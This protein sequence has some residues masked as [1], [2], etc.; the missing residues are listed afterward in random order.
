MSAKKIDALEKSAIENKKK[1]EQLKAEVEQMKAVAA[2]YAA[3]AEKAA[4]AG[5]VEEYKKLKQKET[6]E[7]AVIYVKQASIKRLSAY[8]AD[9]IRP[10]WEEFRKEHDAEF[11]KNMKAYLETRQKLCEQ[12]KGIMKAQKEAVKQRKRLARLA[13]FSD[14]KEAIAAFP[15]TSVDGPEFGHDRVF[16]QNTNGIT[17]EESMECLNLFSC[18]GIM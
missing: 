16:F 10:A 12:F 7:N 9:D 5:N 3:E 8:N 6:D 2:S 18:K 14:D 15:F 11:S 17:H 13:K 1:A 4:E